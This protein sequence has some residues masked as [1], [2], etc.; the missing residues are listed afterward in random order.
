MYRK[1]CVSEVFA[2]L[3]CVKKVKEYVY[4]TCVYEGSD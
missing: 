2:L 3:I 1:E 4:V